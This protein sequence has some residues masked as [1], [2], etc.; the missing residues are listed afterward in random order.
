MLLDAP[1]LVEEDYQRAS[2]G[3]DFDHW[4]APPKGSVHFIQEM[5]A[6][7]YGFV[8]ELILAHFIP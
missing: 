2:T 4:N 3:L 1:G 6:S 5:A 8:E 7:E